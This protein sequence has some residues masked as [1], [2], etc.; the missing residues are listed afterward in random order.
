MISTISNRLF[1]DA[2]LLML[3]ILN[4]IQFNTIGKAKDAKKLN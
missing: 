2:L 4:E 1:G 3:L